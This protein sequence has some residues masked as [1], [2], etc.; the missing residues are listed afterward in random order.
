MLINFFDLF[1][2]L[3]TYSLVILN[4]LFLTHFLLNFNNYVRMQQI[5]LTSSFF[6]TLNQRMS[7][8][9]LDSLLP[10]TPT[11]LK[12]LSHH[13]RVQTIW[14]QTQY[15]HHLGSIFMLVLDH[16]EGNPY[17]SRY[18]LVNTLVGIILF[19]YV[20]IHFLIDIW[21]E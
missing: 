5:I 15:F 9:L 7:D 13:L 4:L 3:L 1:R 8:Q 12:Y 14:K 16:I 11:L 18:D 20:V 19:G 21:L 2:Q 6:N 17:S 10:F